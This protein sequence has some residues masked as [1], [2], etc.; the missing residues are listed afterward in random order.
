MSVIAYKGFDVRERRNYLT[1][2]REKT[3]ECRGFRFKEGKTYEEAKAV[4]CS[5]GF[6]AC[7]YPLDV[8]SYYRSSLGAPVEYH[9]VELE[10]VSHEREIDSKICARKITIGRKISTDEMIEISWNFPAEPI[11]NFYEETLR[12][13]FLI[14]NDV[15]KVYP[16][17]IMAFGETL[18]FYSPVP[19]GSLPEQTIHAGKFIENYSLWKGVPTQ[20]HLDEYYAKS[21]RSIEVSGMLYLS[22][23]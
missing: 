2:K 14:K 10:H 23:N 19:L 17:S 12:A 8:F 22:I 6:H 18:Y 20:E 7:T 4:L 9:V 3:L 5:C 15:N 13:G 11:E 21:K 1:N 16:A